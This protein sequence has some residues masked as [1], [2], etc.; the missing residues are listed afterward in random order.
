MRIS[1]VHTHHLQSVT[2][3]VCTLKLESWEISQLCIIIMISIPS[4][5]HNR[6][7]EEEEEAEERCRVALVVGAYT[8]LY[9]QSPNLK[10]RKSIRC[11]TKTYIHRESKVTAMHLI[12]LTTSRPTT[13]VNWIDLYWMNEWT[14]C[15][16]A[17]RGTW[18]LRQPQRVF[19]GPL[20]DVGYYYSVFIDTRRGGGGVGETGDG[21][22]AEF[23][24]SEQWNGSSDGH[25]KY[26]LTRYMP[27]LL[28][29]T[30]IF[31]VVVVIGLRRQKEFWSLDD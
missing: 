26:I 17:G 28:S 27:L 8:V 31:N 21:Q 18:A 15:V 4:L 7:A 20:I 14:P 5:N 9:T 29:G 13:H 2:N 30:K 25:I 3:L 1:N 22:M 19:R 12:W 10:K 23:G 6:A 16:A 24:F 11:K